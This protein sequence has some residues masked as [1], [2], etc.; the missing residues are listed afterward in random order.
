MRFARAV[1]N[2]AKDELET[3]GL[4]EL[5]PFRSGKLFKGTARE[6]G[7]GAKDL[8]AWW[9]QLQQ[10]PNPIRREMHLF[11]LLSG[12]RRQDV[13]TAVGTISMKSAR[14][15]AS[16]RQRAAKSV[17]LNFPSPTPMLACLKRAKALGNT[18]FPEQ[19][20]IWVFPAETG[21]VAEVKEDGQVKLSHTG[22]AL[23]HSFRTL[24]GA[25]GIDR[26]RLKILMNHA[27]ERDVTDSYANVPALFD[28]LM[29]AQRR[30]S[31]RSSSMI[32]VQSKRAELASN[33]VKMSLTQLRQANTE[34]K[35][36]KTSW[37]KSAASTIRSRPFSD[38]MQ[39]R[40]LERQKS[41]LRRQ[42]RN[43]S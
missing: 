10:L 2:F 25:A 9:A 41:D 39:Q 7:M 32:A 8:P 5:N 26:L 3:L 43:A 14:R 6:N 30:I 42:F 33:E 29:D 40:K 18:F 23:R 22:H 38:N 12:L 27:V 21:H 16:R 1:W 34:M 4:P 20:R 13:L 15:C 11:M 28:S 36:A 17:P 37:R 24:A 35:N 19:S 31:A